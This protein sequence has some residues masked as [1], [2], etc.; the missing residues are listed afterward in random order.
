MSIKIK[1]N[2]VVGS[3]ENI[4]S[5]LEIK[6]PV[7]VAY[8][9][10][11]LVNKLQPTLTVYEENRTKLIKEYGDVQED[12]NTSVK[13][14]EKLKLFAEELGKLLEVEEEIDFDKIN[15]DELEGINIEAKL[16]V[17]WIFE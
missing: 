14:P 11:K 6:L 8:R 2:D 4:K 1:V 9:I 10:S 13:D 7:K 12:G 3:V 17:S 16:L 5:L 15:V